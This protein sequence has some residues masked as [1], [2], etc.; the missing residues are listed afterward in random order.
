MKPTNS[1][2]DV[3]EGESFTVYGD[4]TPDDWTADHFGNSAAAF[5][6][7]SKTLI[8]FFIWRGNTFPDKLQLSI[9]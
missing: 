6:S 5:C 9:F 3:L 8:E 4:E 7:Q 2:P 1:L